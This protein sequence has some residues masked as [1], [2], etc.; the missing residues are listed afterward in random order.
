[1]T[2]HWR[3]SQVLDGLEK[4]YQPLKAAWSNATSAAERLR[5][6]LEQR[7]GGRISNGAVGFVELCHVCHAENDM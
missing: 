1:M 3:T 5:L 7:T 2:S 6:W 4:Q